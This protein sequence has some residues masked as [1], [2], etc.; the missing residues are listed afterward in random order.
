MTTSRSPLRV[1]VAQARKIAE[2]MKRAERGEKID[3]AFAAKIE[4]ARG[5]EAV[6][7]GVVMDD[8]VVTVEVAWRLVRETSEAGLA[9]HVLKL[10]RESRET[11]H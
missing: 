7:F 8:K 6:K 3:V 2:V 5:R 11:R 1:L 4:N 10:M 9:E